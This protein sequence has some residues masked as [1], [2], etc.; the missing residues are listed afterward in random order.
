LY[1][2]ALQLIGTPNKDIPTELGKI[3]EEIFNIT[4]QSNEEILRL[5]AGMAAGMND[6]LPRVSAQ[7]LNPNLELLF[8]GPQLRPFNF[9]FNLIAYDKE[10]SDIIKKIIKFFKQNMAVQK[11]E[12]YLFLR[13]PHVFE[14]RYMSKGK[15]GEQDHQSI[16]LITGD[17]TKTE[18]AKACA[19]LNCSVDYTPLGSYMT[20]QDEE[21]SMVQYTLNLQFQEITPVYDED[22]TSPEHP[23]GF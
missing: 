1:K 5:V 8:Q 23:I 11:T 6:I 4:K 20:F 18:N 13:A 3:G 21:K 12:N 10:E 16:N 19:L 7:I 15:N 2:K 22:Y 14:I 9:T 17:S